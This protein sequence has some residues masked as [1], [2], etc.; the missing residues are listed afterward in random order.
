MG[1][2]GGA[3]AIYSA[4]ADPSRGFWPAIFTAIAPGTRSYIISGHTRRRRRRRPRHPPPRA[5][6]MSTVCMARA[7][8]VTERAAAAAVAPTSPSPG[9]DTD[10]VAS[11]AGAIA[12]AWHGLAALSRERLDSGRVLQ[13]LHDADSP[14]TCDVAAL[15]QLAAGVF[16]VAV[17]QRGDWPREMHVGACGLRLMRSVRCGPA[18]PPSA[19]GSYWLGF[20]RATPVLV[21]QLLRV[22]ANGPPPPRQVGRRTQW[23]TGQPAWQLRRRSLCPLGPRRRWRCCGATRS[24]RRR[25]AAA[26]RCWRQP[27]R[28]GWSASRSLVSLEQ[29]LD[30]S[31]WLHFTSECQ[32]C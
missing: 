32:R 1:R 30:E 9:G 18:P 14:G 21:A 23:R 22:E 28:R 25:W 5:L 4:I 27:A 12:G 2:R 16:H 8:A 24:Q 13:R 6:S 19:C 11:C 29:L 7:L 3:R 31:L 10:T 17:R 26:A 15:R 20:R